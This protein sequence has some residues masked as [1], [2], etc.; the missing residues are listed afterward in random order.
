MIRVLVSAHNSRRRCRSAELR[1]RRDTSS[2][3]IAPTSPTQTRPTSS[4]NPERADAVRPDTPRSASI[5]EIR[6]ALQPSRAASCTSAYWR[7]VDSVCSRTC[8]M[9]DWRTYT[10]ADRSRWAAVILPA[11]VIG[12]SSSER[13]LDH[14]RHDYHRVPRRLGHDYSVQLTAA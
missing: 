4:L 7:A 6:S 12:Q 11:A 1:A 5:T 2:P 10:T 13:G 14:V 8:A 9:V 3:R